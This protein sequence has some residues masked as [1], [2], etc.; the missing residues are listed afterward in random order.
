L[1]SIDLSGSLPSRSG[2]VAL[3]SLA[4]SLRRL[5]LSRCTVVNDSNLCEL[6]RL[7]PNIKHV[8]I[9]GCPSVSYSTIMLLQKLAPHAVIHHSSDHGDALEA[10]AHVISYIQP[11]SDRGQASK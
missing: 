6:L 10:A 8:D 5:Q 1:A 11:I 4:P 9:T 3:T 7:L 2:L